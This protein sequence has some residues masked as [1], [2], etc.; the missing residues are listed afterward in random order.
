MRKLIIVIERSPT[1]A[2]LLESYLRK[3]HQVIV[4]TT[5]QEVLRLFPT[6]VKPPDVIFLALDPQWPEEYQFITF[7]KRQSKYKDTILIAMVDQ[8]EQAQVARRLAGIHVRY[9][10]KPFK[11]EDAC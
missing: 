11:I 3:D 1:I 8:E 10:L 2:F 7:L 4:R 6:I 9:L 5:P